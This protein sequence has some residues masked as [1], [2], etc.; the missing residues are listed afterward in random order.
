[1]TTP[2]RILLID[3]LGSWLAHTPALRNLEQVV[4]PIGLMSISSNLKQYFKGRIDVA[5]VHLLVD[6]EGE[7]DLKE[8]I[9]AYQP[10]LVGVRGLHIYRKE[11]HEV[12]SIVRSSGIQRVI[13]GGPYATSSPGEALSGHDLDCVVVGE[14]E[15]TF[16]D[17]VEC[18]LD[19]RDFREVAGVAFF[20]P[21]S[22]SIVENPPRAF[23]SDLDSLEDPDYSV[24]DLS[25]YARFLTYGYNRRRQAVILSSRGCPFECAYCHNIFGR[26]FRMRSA[27]RVVGEIARLH[28]NFGISDFYFID[29]NFNMDIPRVRRFCE[30]MMHRNLGVRLYFANGLRGDMLNPDLI[31]AL[32]EAGTVAMTFAVETASDRIQR[33]IRKFNKL[34]VLAR[35]IHHACDR[36]IMVS[37]CFMIG[38]PSETVEEATSTIEFISQFDRVVLPMFFSV[39]YYPD[40]D[41]YAMAR[42][43]GIDVGNADRAFDEA[44]HDISHSGTPTIPNAAFQ[45]IYFQFLKNVFLSRRRL[46]NALA[47]QRKYFDESELLDV[48][49]L[50]FRRRIRNIEA[51][52][53]RFASSK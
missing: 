5:I 18:L 4:L 36:E 3:A 51:D 45:S 40:T 53:L 10:D 7:L 39:K 30:E 44:Y 6:C 15:I 24:I 50:F 21:A 47:I 14:G 13:G 22:L 43:H 42:E 41:I 26:R 19:G 20:D 8:R 12:V 16:R 52:V 11:F 23:I 29:D 48:Y 1:M 38:F 9:L 37:V 2:L 34:D 32:I 35:N 25:R 31:D 33:L 17:I 28:E 27:E 46:E 49:S